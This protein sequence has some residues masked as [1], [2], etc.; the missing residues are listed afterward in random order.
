MKVS[1][2]SVYKNTGRKITCVT[3]YDFTSASWV[4]ESP[5]DC[6]LVGDS[7]GM[8]I[9][10]DA[11]TI[12]VDVG[13]IER[14]TRSVAKGLGEQFLIADMPFMSYRKGLLPA[15]NAVEKLI[16]AGAHAVKVEGVHGHE[17]IIHHI[18]ESGVPVVGHIGLIPQSIHGLGGY[19]VQGK[20]QSSKERLLSEARQLADL[21]CCALV[22]ECV[23]TEVAKQITSE[24][25]I[26]TIGIGAGADTDGQILVWQDLLGLTRGRVPK[27]AR[28]FLAGGEGIASALNEYYQQVQSSQFPSAEESYESL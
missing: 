11:T 10:G 3:C 16:K 20:D 23:T 8:V 15:M 6:V 24:V 27:F 25:P 2:F 5:I 28:H 9:Y 12:N 13:D 7:L 22:L 4:A 14:H 19:R 18:V 1:D 26:A 21:G 17:T